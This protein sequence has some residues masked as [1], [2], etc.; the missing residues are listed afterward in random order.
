LFIKIKIL[1][2][3]K[4]EKKMNAL[5][6][7]MLALLLASQVFSASIVVGEFDHDPSLKSVPPRSL[8]TRSNQTANQAH[9]RSVRSIDMQRIGFRDKLYIKLAQ[10]M[11][12]YRRIINKYQDPEYRL[13]NPAPLPILNYT[14]PYDFIPNEDNCVPDSFCPDQRHSTVRTNLIP[15]YKAYKLCSCSECFHADGPCARK[16]IARQKAGCEEEFNYELAL[17]LRDPNDRYNIDKWELI[18]EQVLIA[19]KCSMMNAYKT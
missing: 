19:C 1:E 6:F 13:Y 5:T 14:K 11:R 12:R 9:H 10:G 8:K 15:E 18:L 7:V 3:E 2:E 16:K 17:I 4:K